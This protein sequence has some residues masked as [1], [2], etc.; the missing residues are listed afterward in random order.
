MTHYCYRV[1]RWNASVAAW[2]DVN[3]FSTLTDA[4]KY[5]RQAEGNE[6]SYRI[7]CRRT[8]SFEEV[9]FA[10]YT[11]EQGYEYLPEEK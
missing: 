3:C 11:P 7:L 4:L 1:Q 2:H 10:R 6:V 8:P 9:V 5:L